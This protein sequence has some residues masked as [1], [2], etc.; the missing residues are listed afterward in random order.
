[1]FCFIVNTLKVWLEVIAS[2]YVIAAKLYA[3]KLSTA[4]VIGV[5]DFKDQ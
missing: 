4:Q 3:V 2:L 5:N 1:M